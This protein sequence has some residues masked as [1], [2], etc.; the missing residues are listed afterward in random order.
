VEDGGGVLIVPV[1]QDAGEQ[2]QVTAGGKW[3]KEVS[4]D[5]G[6]SMSQSCG[7]ECGLSE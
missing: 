1:V 4:L 2:V 3:I 5:S 7:L 6:C